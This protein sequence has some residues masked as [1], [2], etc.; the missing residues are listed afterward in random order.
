M[1]TELTDQEKKF[2]TRNKSE[3]S[4]FKIT[5]ILITTFLV[6][7]LI[8]DGFN[9]FHIIRQAKSLAWGIGGLLLLS[10]LYLIGEAGSEWISSKDNVSNPLYKRAFHLVLLLGFVGVL[11]VVLSKLFKYL[12]W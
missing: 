1:K 11:A 10:I 3:E 9:G 7:G 4:K 5:A 6:L 8:L 2:F 12:G